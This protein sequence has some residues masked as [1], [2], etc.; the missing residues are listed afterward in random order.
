[1]VV[2]NLVDLAAVSIKFLAILG[3]IYPHLSIHII[4]R[5]QS[6]VESSCVPDLS[7]HEVTPV[8]G[9]T[10]GVLGSTGLNRVTITLG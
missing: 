9:Q 5:Y 2:H 3:P 8:V 7:D 4:G 10:T 6:G 1:M